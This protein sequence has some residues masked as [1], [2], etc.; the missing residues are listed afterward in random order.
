MKVYINY[1]IKNFV[2]SIIFVFLILISLI[3]I[4]NIL[5]EIEFFK[6]IEVKQY[7][8]IALAAI[9]T[10][11]LIFEMFPFIFL[12]S[13][14]IF[15]LNLFNDNQIQIFKY[16]GL[17]NTQ[18]I[19]IITSTAFFIGFLIIIFFYNFSSNLKN[20]YLE[21]KFKHTADDKYLAVIT[22]NGLWIK[23]KVENNISIIN[24]Q[25]IDKNFL[26][27]TFITEFDK[28]FN[29]IRNIKSK[30]VDINRYD[31]IIYDAEVYKDGSYNKYPE[32]I[33]TS[34]FDY[35]KIKNL[36]SNLSS[37][38]LLELF[39]LKKNYKD[40][41]YSTTE[42][43]IE[44]HKILSYPIYLTLMTIFAAFMMLNFKELHGN[45]LKIIIGLFLSVIIYYIN[46]FF[47]VMGNTEKLSVI[48]SIWMPQLFLIFLNFLMM[49]KINEK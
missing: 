42:V 33:V 28:D 36:F 5:G 46:N 14:Q 29:V 20:Y 30:K 31:W 15:F 21:L 44:I 49:I 13:T 32:I 22:N 12:I 39:Q 1:L 45:T 6:N 25:K 2:S 19:K 34:N 24:A 38:S 3:F 17:K 16:S 23:D 37:L 18:I 7:Y 8:P 35:R 11:S 40:L 41:N 48:T 10:P 9:N 43:N 4:L 27:N 47:Y 26:I